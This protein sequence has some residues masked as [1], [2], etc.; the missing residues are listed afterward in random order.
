M[1][2]TDAKP[3]NL[4]E[5]MARVGYSAR[6]LVYMMVGGLAA[7]AAIGSG[8]DVTG[9]KGAMQS[10]LSQPMGW[11]LLG[12][13]AL[14]LL[15][16]A[17]WRI[18][19]A[20]TDADCGDI[21]GSKAVT[22]RAI[23]VVSGIVYF[24]L[25]W[26]AG[27]LALGFASSGSGDSGAKGW[28]AWLLSQ[29]FGAWLVAAGG[30]IIAGVGLRFAWK[31]FTEDFSE[32]LRG[33][34]SEWLGTLGTVGYAA[35]GI[36]FVMIGIFLIVAGYQSDPSNAEGLGGALRSLQEQPYGWILLGLTALGLAAFGAFNLS[37]GIYGKIR[38]PDT[39]GKDMSFS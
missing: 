26:W 15:F 22:K 2:V 30:L 24:G 1:D 3:S 17:I 23:C 5:T 14:G 33:E 8:G 25:A 20:T 36:V 7:L 28:T 9:S 13:I 6:G 19:Q 16:F 12:L 4:L 32:G 39:P 27:K 10:F 31:A 35:R 29:P 18:L 11:I 34:P 38:M 21:S 37:R